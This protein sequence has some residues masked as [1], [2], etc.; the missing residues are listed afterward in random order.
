MKA[1]PGPP[2][3]YGGMNGNGWDVFFLSFGSFS[4]GGACIGIGMKGG[5]NW[6]F[7]SSGFFS[8]AAGIGND[9]G[10]P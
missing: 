7:S 4:G 8:G 1:G 10:V 3:L 9:P 5:M 2:E 6:T